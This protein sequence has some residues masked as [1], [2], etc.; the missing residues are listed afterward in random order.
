MGKQTPLG[1]L[2]SWDIEREKLLEGSV[3][4]Q[5]GNKNFPCPRRVPILNKLPLYAHS[6]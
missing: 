5:E 2:H 6:Q 3:H 1:S 4:L